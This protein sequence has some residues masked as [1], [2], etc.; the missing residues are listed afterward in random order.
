MTISHEI[1]HA[2][3]YL[4]RLSNFEKYKEPAAWAYNLAYAKT[5]NLTQIISLIRPKVT[6]Y[7][8]WWSWRNIY[9]VLPT[10]KVF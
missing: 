10:I 1:I 8:D 3:Q 6:W 7:P 5:H 9:K 4:Q 2:H